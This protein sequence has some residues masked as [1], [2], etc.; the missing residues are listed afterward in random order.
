MQSASVSAEAATSYVADGFSVESNTEAPDDI[1][2]NFESEPK[3][4]E[5]D[6]ADSL[7]KAA[8]ELGKKG[9]KAAAEKRAERPKL[10]AK[11]AEKEEADDS[12]E[13]E[14]ERKASGG[15]LTRHN[16]ATARVQDALSKQKAAE[17]RAQQL[18]ARLEA[19][20]RA[21]QAPPPQPEQR[22]QPQTRAAN[23]DEDDPKPKVDD[24]DSYEEYAEKLARWSF[25]DEAKKAAQG[26]QEAQR[27]HAVIERVAAPLQ[28]TREAIETSLREDPSIKDR[29]SRDLLAVKPTYDI[30]SETGRVGKLRGRIGPEN[31]FMHAVLSSENAVGLMLHLSEHTNVPE[32]LQRIARLPDRESVIREVAKLEARLEA[33]VTTAPSAKPV[34]KAHPPVRP[35]TGA[36]STDVDSDDEDEDFDAMM[37]RR[38]GRERSRR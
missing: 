20:E 1:K 14:E 2:K 34:S 5:P 7:S 19:L 9:G 25:R 23:D 16:N 29:V 35:V 26:M 18:E 31:D 28:R 22:Q 24:H 33:A 30:D 12:D 10:E 11:P 8:S 27:A 17:Q 21:R 6:E 32:F 37:R 13:T 4:G 36:P 38:T 3:D 15:K